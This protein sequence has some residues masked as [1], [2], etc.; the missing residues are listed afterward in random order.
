M[1]GYYSSHR[2]YAARKN[3]PWH[4]ASD[5]YAQNLAVGDAVV[6]ARQWEDF[7]YGR[8][9]VAIITNKKGVYCDLLICGET[10]E[11][12]HYSRLRKAVA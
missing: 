6:I 12:V 11:M 4:A 9:Q 7:A 3:K 2:R 5:G 1:L 8:G 10:V